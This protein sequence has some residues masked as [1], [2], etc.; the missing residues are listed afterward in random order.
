MMDQPLVSV[1]VPAYNSSRF[2]RETVE[3]ALRQTRPVLE[4]I[5]VDDGS[6][7]R[8]DWVAQLDPQRVTY[9]WQPN[10]GPASARNFGIRLSR[11]V[12]VAFLDSDDVWEP[13]K[14]EQQLRRLT[15]SP[16]AELV[17]TAVV[18]IDE[19]GQA[20]SGLRPKGGE[21]GRIFER[22][23]EHN[24]ITTSTVLVRRASLINAGAFDER[25]ELMAVEDY[26]MWL[27]LAER[28]EVAYVAEPLVRYRLH[29][30]GISRNTGRSYLG[31]KLVIERAIVRRDAANPLTRRAYHRRMA[32]LFFAWGHECFSA[33]KL[34]EARAPLWASLRH[35]PWSFTGWGYWA[36]TF[37][38]PSLIQSVRRVK[39][40]TAPATG[41]RPQRIMYLNQSL[42]MGGIE[43]LILELCKRLDR[44]AYATCVCVFEDGGMLVREF[45]AVGVPV[46]VVKKGRGV[47][48]WL[49]VRLARLARREG[50]D[51]LHTHNTAAW[52]YG[53]LAAWLAGVP[54]VHTEHTSPSYHARRW[55]KIE[56][57]L[58]LATA[59]ISAVSGSVARVM[60]EQQGIAAEKV[61]V[62][63]NGIEAAVYGA[64]ADGAGLKETLGV[65]REAPVVGNVARFFPNKD[66]RTLLQAFTRVVER[67]PS[68][69][70][71]IAGEG[72][73][74]SDI[75]EE[76]RKLRLSDKVRLLGNRRDIPALLR[77]FDLFALSSVK[78]G[79]PIVLLEAMASGVPVVATEVDGNPELVVHQETGLLV[80]PRNPDA[81]AEAI[82]C[83]LQDC[84]AARR[85]GERGRE[86]VRR[87]FTFERM[88]NAYQDVY[89]SVARR[90]S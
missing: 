72:P 13:Y 47:D 59:R 44:A 7:D 20:T 10:G 75:E 58:S 33:N 53:V 65:P 24:F 52:F 56:N 49:P 40:T 18:A 9:R 61:R 76:I 43:T 21:E 82:C 29:V 88:V 27:R 79:L 4:V 74:R 26:D 69:M 22:L 67:V 12:Y 85:M 8:V 14:L 60:T 1:I 23:F 63:H 30:A 42:G 55:M 17:Y 80:P 32:N 38:S 46:H 83:L 73:L 45:E 86:R 36:A 3:S 16:Q 50:V 78:E 68:A 66:H 54:V 62:I 81:L 77:V 48:W 51:V 37:L 89:G 41:R 6:T 25:R 64:A 2:I 35:R 31:E 57:T 70:L 90:P 28:V 15:Q 34:A 84:D 39:G 5:V 11:G 71:L 87:L 19:Q